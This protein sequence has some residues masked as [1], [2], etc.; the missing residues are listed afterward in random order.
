MKRTVAYP[1]GLGLS[2]LP[3][4]AIAAHCIVVDAADIAIPAEKEVNV[5]HAPKTY[6]KPAMGMAPL[7]RKSVV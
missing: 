7:D 3:T 4:P 5:A 1:D 6:M 2:D